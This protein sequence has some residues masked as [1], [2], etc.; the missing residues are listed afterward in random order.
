M[1]VRIFGKRGTRIVG[2]NGIIMSGD[3]PTGAKNMFDTLMCVREF[4]YTKFPF[5]PTVQL[6]LFVNILAAM[7]GLAQ[8]TRNGRKANKGPGRF[9][10][11]ARDDNARLTGKN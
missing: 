5:S 3:S 7:T 10:T 2:E 4:P 8:T 1:G 9:Q 6:P 11:A